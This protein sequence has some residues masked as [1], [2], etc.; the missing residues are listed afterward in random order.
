MGSESLLPQPYFDQGHASLTMHAQWMGFQ[1]ANFCIRVES[2][3]CLPESFH[4]YTAMPHVGFV[5][6]P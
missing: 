3:L 2:S 1:Y 6:E 4:M 5:D